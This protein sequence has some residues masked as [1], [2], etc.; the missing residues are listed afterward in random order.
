MRVTKIS[1]KQVRIE[2][3][4]KVNLFLE[5]LNKR[6]DGY[7]NINS[8]FQ[9]VS[10]ADLLELEITEKPGIQIDLTPPGV[11][12]TDE[13]NLVT[14]AL[15]L[16]RDRFSVASGLRVRLEKNI[17]I[18]AGLAGG[19]SD[20]A[21][22]ILACNVLFG[23]GLEVSEMAALGLELGSDLPFFF[24]GGQALVRGRGELLEETDLPTDYWL[25]MVVPQVAI[26]TRDSYA[27]LNLG[28][29]TGRKAF[30]LDGCQ[31]VKELVT[32]LRLTG[33]DFEK[34]Q[35]SSYPELG[36]IKEGLSEGG[37]MLARMSGSGSTV[38]GIFAEE[39]SREQVRSLR[40]EG[41]QVYTVRPVF[42]GRQ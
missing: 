32:A 8:L 19:S 36:R 26:S 35:I 33:N 25:A 4:A 37:A 15:R 3:P 17:P 16:V 13:Q 6:E 7:H 34:V 31:T 21:A 40:R 23:L 28:L 22:A 42:L 1:K 11:L 18:A 9:A 5:V 14:G 41:W 10:L 12:P 20:G 30:S 29:T 38:F 2:A 39:P 24:S 27:R